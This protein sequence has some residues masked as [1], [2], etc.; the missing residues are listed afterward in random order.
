MEIKNLKKAA[1]RILEGTEK[2]EKIFLYPDADLDGVCSAVII[3]ETVESLGGKIEKIYFS[4]R[5]K[6]G[7]GVSEV[8]LYFLKNFGPGLLITLDC[9]ITNFSEI[10]L[11]RELG[12]ETIIIDHHEI[13]ERVPNAEIVVDPKQKDDPYPFK[14]LATV[15]IVFKLVEEILKEKLSNGMRANFLELVAL[16][17]L[18]DMVPQEGENRLWIKEGMESMK[19]SFR[20]AIQVIKNYFSIP[21]GIQKVISILN[22]RLS[23]ENNS[24]PIFSFLTSPTLEEAEKLFN[25]FLEKF[26]KRKEELKKILAKI[27]TLIKDEKIIFL[28]EENWDFSLIPS[29]ASQVCQIYK[30]PTFIFKKNEKESVGSVRCPP[31]VNSVEL[32]KKCKDFLISFGG[33]PGASGFRIKNENLEDFK[34]CLLE[35]L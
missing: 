18:A 26:E 9:G 1:E 32:M 21:N 24:S 8:G 5:E 11:A 4:D 33:H 7:Y 15:G 34:K 12:F 31:Q 29:I 22:V 23:F 3:K 16:A 25:L 2:K 14:N 27:K 6:E 28:G 17:T 35:N 10:D 30:K 19:R 20:P 13:V